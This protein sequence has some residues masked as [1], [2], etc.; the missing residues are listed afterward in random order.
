MAKKVTQLPTTTVLQNSDKIMVVTN[1]NGTP[2]SEEISK[3]N[4]EGSLNL[5]SSNASR[6][7]SGGMQH[8]S[9]LTYQSIDLIYEILG[10]QFAITDGT[11][12]T[13]DTADPTDPRLDLIFGDDLG[14]LDKSTGTPAPT[15]TANTL[16]SNQFQLKLALVN[17]LATE[18]DGVSKR[19]VYRE[20][21]GQSTEFDATENTSGARI[22][23]ANTSSPLTGTKDIKTIATINNGD[24]ITFVHA[25]PTTVVNLDSIDLDFKV[26][27]D[28]GNDYIILKLLDNTTEVGV[29][30]IDSSFLDFTNTT[31]TQT[32]TIFKSDFSLVTG[33]TE[34]DKITIFHRVRGSS[35]ILYQ[36]DEIFIFEDA[37]GTQPTSVTASDVSVDT[38]NFDTNLSS[39]DDTVQKALETI[40]DLSLG[41]TPTESFII[42]VSN[43]ET[44]LTV[45]TSV[46]YFDFPYNFTITEIIGTAKTAPTGASIIADVNV[47][48]STIMTTNKVEIEATEVSSLTATTQPTITD[49]VHLKGQR[50]TVDIDQIGSTIAG[51]DLEIQIIG[52]QT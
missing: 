17:A 25:T 38:S 19:T 10:Q 46:G 18:P 7:I 24:L 22:D 52:T 50:L 21:V 11:T 5:S 15:P 26:L 31:S 43:F 34:F 47:D 30:N 20:D 6:L 4:F 8:V 45:S 2:V 32:V 1:V 40:N 16:P 14:V 36:L 48:G 3:Q 49:A 28:W 35:S 12:V 23:L 41:G 33:Q 44:D 37:N 29:V 51:Q 27:T 13:L 42:T 9:G 39:A